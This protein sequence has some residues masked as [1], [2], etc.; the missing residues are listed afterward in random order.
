MDQ[1]S[2][3]S[4]LDSMTQGKFEEYLT[5]IWKE[6][7]LLTADEEI[8]LEEYLNGGRIAKPESD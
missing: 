8:W 6:K 5:A 2:Y 1:I 3:I 7:I 4:F